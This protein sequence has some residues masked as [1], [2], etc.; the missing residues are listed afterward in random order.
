MG[1][2]VLILT[3]LVVLVAIIWKQIGGLQKQLCI[4]DRKLNALL[5]SIGLDPLKA[6]FAADS[7]KRIA[8]LY[9]S[10]KPD[11]AKKLAKETLISVDE[12]KKASQACK[13][14]PGAM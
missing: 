1:S 8:E 13:E 14:K 4:Q 9:Q 3:M 2:V 11:E 5:A 12:I 10:G 7:I 6:D